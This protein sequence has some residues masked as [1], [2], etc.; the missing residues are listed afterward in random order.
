MGNRKNRNSNGKYMFKGNRYTSKNNT[1]KIDKN[2]KSAPTASE[3]KLQN[4]SKMSSTVENEDILRTIGK[5]HS[6]ARKLCSAINVNF[7]SMTAFR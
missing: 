2:I 3:I 4:D 7:P 5:G 6:A 1:N